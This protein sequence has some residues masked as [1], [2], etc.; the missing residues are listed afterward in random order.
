MTKKVQLMLLNWAVGNRLFE[1]PYIGHE[2]VK[3]VLK[4]NGMRAW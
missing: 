1:F 2:A 4:D 3:K